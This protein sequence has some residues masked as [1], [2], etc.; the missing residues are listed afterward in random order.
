M[1][2]VQLSEVCIQVVYLLA[3][4]PWLLVPVIRSCQSLYGYG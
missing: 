3:M 2:C 1:S 4:V